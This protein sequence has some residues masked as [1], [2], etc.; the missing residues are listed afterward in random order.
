MLTIAG[1]WIYPVKS[2]GGVA[3]TRAAIS[4][5]GSL[6]G[7]RE[8][9]VVDAEDRMVWQGDLPRMTLLRVGRGL[10]WLTIDAPDGTSLA[11]DAEHGGARRVVTQ[12]RNSFEGVDAGDEAAAF[13]SAW[14]GTPCRLVR[15]GTLA[16]RWPKANPLH[17]LSDLSLQALNDRLAETGEG[18]LV[19][20]R[21]RPNVLLT[22]VGSAFDEETTSMIDFGSAA[23]ILH[24]PCKRCVLPNISLIDGTV[25]RQPLKT[26]A[27]MSRERSTSRTASLGV[28]SHARGQHLAVGMTAKPRLGGTQPPSRTARRIGAVPDNGDLATSEEASS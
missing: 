22:G 10:G 1:L 27:R 6:A 24:W 7:D 12:Y 28:Y 9:L 16:Y 13:L 8:W 3:V 25:E 18:P 23:I 17:V 19:V 11:I 2:L 26:I 21:F 4:P 20:E 14:L 15:I 5:E